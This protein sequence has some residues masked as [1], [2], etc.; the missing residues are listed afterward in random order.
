MTNVAR[1]V[2]AAP[3][4]GVALPLGVAL[5][6]RAGVRPAVGARVGL[7]LG[8]IAVGAT[9]VGAASVGAT[10]GALKAGL[11]GDSGATDGAQA[12]VND[13]NA[14]VL[15][16]AGLLHAVANRVNDSSRPAKSVNLVLLIR[17]F[18]SNRAKA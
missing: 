16:G 1:L 17:L 10:L 7:V 6:L 2:Q 18:S 11:V 9:P 14:D 13:G 15:L 3:A 5:A 4:P 8:A 12:G